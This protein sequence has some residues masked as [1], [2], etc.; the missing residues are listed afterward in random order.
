M[1]IREI[2]QKIVRER[3]GDSKIRVAKVLAVSGHTCTVE[4]LDTVTEITDVRLQAED[5]NGVYFKPAVDSFVIIAPIEDFEFVVIMYSAIDEIQ[6]L[7]GSYGGLVKIADLITK[8]N[9][10]ENKVNALITFIN[11]HSHAS[12]GAPPS[13]TFL[14]GSLT[15]TNQAEIENPLI[16]HGTV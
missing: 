15:L 9:N 16:S 8:M 2:I 1:E 14:G 5:S 7:D 12:N 3:I 6:F 13:P 4:T 10:L 11:T